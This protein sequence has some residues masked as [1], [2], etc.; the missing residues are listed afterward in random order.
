MAGPESRFRAW[1]TEL[2]ADT[3]GSQMLEFA[4]TLPLLV[5]FVVGIFD[6]GEAFNTKQ[7]LTNIMRQ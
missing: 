2:F 5:V 7:K 1:M 6:F 3:S 4:V